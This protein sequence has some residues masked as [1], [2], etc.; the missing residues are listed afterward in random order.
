MCIKYLLFVPKRAHNF[1][2]ILEIVWRL[3][4]LD[5]NPGYLKHFQFLGTSWQF[6]FFVYNPTVDIETWRFFIWAIDNDEANVAEII[7]LASDVF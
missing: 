7:P 6:A 4:I 3:L 1:F 2:N 5:T